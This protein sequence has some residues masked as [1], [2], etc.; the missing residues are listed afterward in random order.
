MEENANGDFSGYRGPVIYQEKDKFYVFYAHFQSEPNGEHRQLWCRIPTTGASKAVN[1][2]TKTMSHQTAEADD[3]DSRPHESAAIE[4]TEGMSK[5]KKSPQLRYYVLKDGKLNSVGN[6]DV[7]KYNAQRSRYIADTMAKLTT[8]HV[9]NPLK[10]IVAFVL[11][12]MTSF[13]MKR[14][15]PQYSKLS[16]GVIA[17]L[18]PDTVILVIQDMLASTLGLT[19]VFPDLQHVAGAGA[20]RSGSAASLT[21]SS[22]SMSL[23]TQNQIQAVVSRSSLASNDIVDETESAR[24]HRLTQT[25]NGKRKHSELDCA[26]VQ[27]DEDDGVRALSFKR[28]MD[29]AARMTH[30]GSARWFEGTRKSKAAREKKKG[31]QDQADKKRKLAEEMQIKED[32]ERKS[33]VEM[34]KGGCEKLKNALQ[35]RKERVQ[36]FKSADDD[37]QKADEE[38]KNEDEAQNETEAAQQMMDAGMQRMEAAK[39]GVRDAGAGQ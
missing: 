8:D 27:T 24:T 35:M 29:E 11:D 32:E 22:P 25:N 19:K 3:N 34:F 12:R 6:N 7:L 1:P 18:N 30:E 20:N 16:A 33:G 28:E 15:I 4:P 14:T 2:K 17:K 26:A 38:Q 36:M 13:D 37:K 9:G 10:L 5:N 31:F 21:A 39:Q 23:E